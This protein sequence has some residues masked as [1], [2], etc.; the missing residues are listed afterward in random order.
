MKLRI[1]PYLL[2]LFLLT[3]C[4][5]WPWGKKDTDGGV[6]KPGTA[7]VVNNAIGNANRSNATANQ[8]QINLDGAQQNANSQTQEILEKTKANI[9]TAIDNNK[10]NPDGKAKVKTNQELEVAD[11]RLSGVK[12]NEAEL[13][14]GK[15]RNDLVDQG[16]LEEARGATAN[17]VAAAKADAAALAEAKVTIENL[18]KERN[19]ANADRDAANKE[20]DAQVGIYTK[21]A[22]EN[23]ADY[24]KKLQEERDGVKRDQ[25]KGLNWAGVI[26]IGLFGLGLGFGGMPGL[27]KTWPFGVIGILCFGLAQL[28][29]QAW[30]MWACLV[31]VLIIVG[32]AIW[33]VIKQH[34]LGNLKVA[35]EE[36]ATRFKDILGTLVPILDDAYEK[37]ESTGKELLDKTVFQPLSTVMNR[38]EKAMVH[39]IRSETT[40]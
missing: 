38:E 4:V 9:L 28:V 1:L 34:K 37:A 29:S 12:P 39:S 32:L 7:Q 33:W 22:E 6:A 17:A 30:F 23:K 20:R 36:Q 31:V 27:M 10:G 18:T 11:A 16:R 3:G 40:Q 26:G 2:S 14:D 5:L 25:A 15:V 8:A 19:T 24:D 21:K 13:A 35:A